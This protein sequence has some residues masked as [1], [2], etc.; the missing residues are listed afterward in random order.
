MTLTVGQPAPTFTL[1]SSDGGTLA[2]DDLRGSIVVLYFYP[3]DNTPGCTI[4]AQE[5]NAALPGLKALGAVV[6]GASRDSIK[7]HCSFRDKFGLGFPLL[8]D[9]DGAVL[10]AYGAWGEK[11]MYGKPV[12]GIIRSTVIIDRDGRVAR[13]FPKVGA[14]GHAADVVAAVEALNA[15][16]AKQPAAA[17]KKQPAAAAKKKPTAPAKQPAAAPK[18]EPAAAAK[19]PAAAPKKKPAAAKKKPAG[20]RR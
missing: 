7:S 12:T 10:T 9:A 20:K 1:P 18:K 17:A 2:L 8:S 3:R 16:P 14:K 5:F 11:L 13:V 15:A 19:K 4:E 6:L